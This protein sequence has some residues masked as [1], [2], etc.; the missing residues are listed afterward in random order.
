MSRAR[1]FGA[2]VCVLVVA[3]VAA[4]SGFA[5]LPGARMC[6]S[7]PAK[8]E[9]ACGQHAYYHGLGVVTWIRKNASRT[10][11][12]GRMQ[13]S[14]QFR[15]TYADHL[16]LMKAGHG[17]I[18]EARTRLAPKP[19]APSVGAGHWALW[20][21]IHNG[22]YPTAPHEGNSTSG[23]YTGYL[24]M[25]SPWMGHSGDWGSMGTGVYAVAEQAWAANGY[26]ISF[27]YH[28]WPQTSPPCVA[29][30]GIG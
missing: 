22:A 19:T 6:G 11:A 10:L 29:K 30:L 28:Q 21:C 7:L 12:S 26:S 15:T 27:L 14:A 17:W 18:S 13:V 4:E 16:W 8:Q 1:A 9:L 3:S 25:T 24:Q 23:L 5:H 20:D 2:F